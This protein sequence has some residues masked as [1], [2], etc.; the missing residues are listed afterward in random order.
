M[1]FGSFHTGEQRPRGR[2]RLSWYRGAEVP[3]IS[4][5][6]WWRNDGPTVEV[7]VLTM[8]ITFYAVVARV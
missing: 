4:K 8:C 2:S 7:V 6:V 3:S 1:I 5:N